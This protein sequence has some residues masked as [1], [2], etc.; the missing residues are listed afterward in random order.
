MKCKKC[1]AFFSLFRCNSPNDC[2]C[3]RCQG[4]CECP[5]LDTATPEFKR[6][7]E[8]CHFVWTQIAPDV[9]GDLDGFEIAEMCMDA[10]RLGMLG[11]AESAAFVRA[12]AIEGHWSLLCEAVGKEMN[13]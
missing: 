10:D 1:E 9:E 7:V 6:L 4:Y 8:D 13:Y 12:T 5:K 2:D 11:R 3:P